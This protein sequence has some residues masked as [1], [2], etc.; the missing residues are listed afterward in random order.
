MDVRRRRRTASLGMIVLLVGL[1]LAPA[2]VSAGT[3]GRSGNETARANVISHGEFVGEVTITGCVQEGVTV[4]DCSV[5][6]SNILC[7]EVVVG[8]SVGGPCSFSINGTIAGVGTRAACAAF[9]DGSGSVSSRAFGSIPH[10]GV[11]TQGAVAGSY[12]GIGNNDIGQVV[13]HAEWATPG[14][15]TGD[16]NGI[17]TGSFDTYLHIVN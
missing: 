12:E 17:A 4:L 3:R 16:I 6:V 10:S 1:L 15:Q 5:N 13:I 14:C 11:I 8:T 9:G 7:L 2:K